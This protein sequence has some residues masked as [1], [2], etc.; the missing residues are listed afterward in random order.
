MADLWLLIPKQLDASKQC[1]TAYA[2]DP[3]VDA[4]P[5]P[6]IHSVSCNLISR[7]ATEFTVLRANVISN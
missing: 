7:I 5:A 6:L 1:F 2:D 4:T 3:Q